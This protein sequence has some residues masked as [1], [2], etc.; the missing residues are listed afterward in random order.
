MVLPKL[1]FLLRRVYGWRTFAKKLKGLPNALPK[2]STFLQRI[3]QQ[4][5]VAMGVLI[6]V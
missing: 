5:V 6:F 3:C 4:E 2:S 1:Q